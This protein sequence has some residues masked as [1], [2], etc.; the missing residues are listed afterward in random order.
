MLGG[1]KMAVIRKITSVNGK[2]YYGISIP[3][4]VAAAFSGVSFTFR[5]SGPDI[6]M[7]SGCGYA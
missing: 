1:V 4:E 7:C 6:L 2:D 3:R 5:Q